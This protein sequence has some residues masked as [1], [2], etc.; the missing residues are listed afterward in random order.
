MRRVISTFV[1]ALPKGFKWHAEIVERFFDIV[2]LNGD[3]LT[4]DPPLSLRHKP[5]CVGLHAVDE[6]QVIALGS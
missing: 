3:V 2:T 6:L 5:L 1:K 4:V